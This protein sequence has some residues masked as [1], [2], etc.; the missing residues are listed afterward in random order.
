MTAILKSRIPLIIADL[1]GTVDD[2]VRETAEA[3]AEGSADRAPQGATGDLAKGYTAEEVEGG[4]AV[5]ALWRWFFTEFGTT[6]SA[7]QPH[8]TPTVETQRLQLSQRVEDAL[9]DL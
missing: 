6:Q 5:M 9:E 8:V 1:P 2:P 3:I 7:P 4:W